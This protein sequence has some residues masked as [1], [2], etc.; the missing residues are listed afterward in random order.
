MFERLIR[1]RF[2]QKH[3]LENVMAAIAQWLVYRSV[4]PMKWV[5]IPLAAQKGVIKMKGEFLHQRF[6]TIRLGSSIET[7]SEYFC[8][9]AMVRKMEL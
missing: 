6:S 5:R 8:R 2:L 4:E 3:W 1:F 9:E 7:L